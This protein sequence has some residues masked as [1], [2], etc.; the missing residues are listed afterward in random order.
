MK[1]SATTQTTSEDYLNTLEKVKEQ[2]QQYLEVSKLYELPTSEQEEPQI[3]HQAPT[4]D[5]PLTT[6]TF[7]M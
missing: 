2:Y 5:N 1:D 6:N 3:E 7:R 4:V